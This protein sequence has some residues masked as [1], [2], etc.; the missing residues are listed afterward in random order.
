ML[1]LDNPARGRPAI[2]MLGKIN[3][4]L[5]PAQLQPM[6]PI[7][8]TARDG[9]IIHGY[10]T[11]PAGAAGHRVPLIM[12]PHG[13]PYG[14]RDDWGFDPEV[15]FLANRGYA[16][17]QPNYRGSGGYGLDFLTAGRHEWG[18]KM[19]DDLTDGVKWAIAQGY[20]DPA[21]VAIL[22]GSY[23]GYAALAGVTFTPEL[24]RC[25]VN[26]VG[27]SDLSIIAG[28]GIGNGRYNGMDRTFQNKLDRRRP[29][30]PP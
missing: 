27:V 14:I 16:V 22:G 28:Y 25:A 11:L 24:Y 30:V 17:L 9:L 29:G 13:G 7:S 8:Y 12:H 2:M 15:Q 5:E 26:Y 10:L 6:Q 1:N 20:A 23:G 4:K 18:G 21:R 19:Q 3:S